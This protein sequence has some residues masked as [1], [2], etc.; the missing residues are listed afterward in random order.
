MLRSGVYLKHFAS[1]ITEQGEAGK[2]PQFSGHLNQ[3]DADLEPE[4]RTLGPG[5]RRIADEQ[6]AI[7]RIL[8]EAIR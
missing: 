5:E 8:K 6:F 2:L 4:K 1:S 7:F 3:W